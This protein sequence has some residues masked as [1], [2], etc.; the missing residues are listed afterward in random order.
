MKRPVD[1]SASPVLMTVSY[2]AL[3]FLCAGTLRWLAAWAYLAVVTVVLA[4]AVV[5]MKRNPELMAERRHPPADAKRWDR[6]LVLLIGALGPVALVVTCGLDRRF[7]WSPAIPAWWKAA[8]LALA[9]AGGMLTNWA[10]A[11]NRFFSALVRIQRDR[12]HRVVDR[13]PY[14]LVRHP[15]YLGSV[16]YMAGAA[17]ALGSLWG[18]LVAG[19][20]TGA[21]VGRTAL[22]DRTLRKELDGYEA[23]AQ[24]VGY[25]LVPGI[26]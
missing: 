11:T 20:V 25:R 23:Y 4:L 18:L 12:G 7:G 15:G 13:G 19:L 10:I 5:L 16:A 22:E 3:L 6:P 26:W 9:G 8:G 2:G 14:R 17:A 21:I 24:R 1:I